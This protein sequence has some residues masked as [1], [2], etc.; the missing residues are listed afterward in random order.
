MWVMLPQLWEY[1]ILICARCKVT[2]KQDSDALIK[3]SAL[4]WAC[5]CGSAP[6]A[7][8]PGFFAV[9]TA[10]ML[11]TSTAWVT[12]VKPASSRSSLI[13]LYV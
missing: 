11:D 7:D 4:P 9:T 1:A 10:A 5:G 3:H 13:S 8:Y 12:S 2:R 6:G